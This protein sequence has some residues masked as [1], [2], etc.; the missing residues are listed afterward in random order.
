MFAGSALVTLLIVCS[1]A[2]ANV[3]LG[4]NLAVAGLLLCLFLPLGSEARSRASRPRRVLFLDFRRHQYGQGVAAGAVRVLNAD[5]RQ[6]I[7]DVK[8]PEAVDGKGAT[9]W[10]VRES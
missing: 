5:K 3:D 6:W 8:Q 4:I 2:V 10:Q 9:Q 7:I 1:L